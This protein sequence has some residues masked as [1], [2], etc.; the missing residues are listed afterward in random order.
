MNFPKLQ[1]ITDSP[2]LAHQACEAGVQWVQAR[3][4]NKTADETKGIAKEILAVC[5]KFNAL[6]IINDYLEMALE[7]NADGVHLGKEDTAI[8]EALEAIKK[9]SFILGGTANTVED[10][11]RLALSHVKYIGLGPFRFTATKEKLSPVLG[12][13]G[14][15]KITSTIWPTNIYFPPIYAIGGILPGDT[16]GILKTGIYGV[17]VSNV[18]S[19]APNKKEIVEEFNARINGASINI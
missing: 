19:Q 2:A 15:T 3:I 16:V 12:L 7:I 5:K 6:C 17:A 10:V 9:R 1:Y 4:K 8:F 13:E 11:R 14:Y 18:I